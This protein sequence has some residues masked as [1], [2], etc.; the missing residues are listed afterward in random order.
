MKIGLKFKITTRQRQ[1]FDLIKRYK[2]GLFLGTACMLL[3]AASSAVSAL[4]I[5]PVMDDIFVKQDIEMLRLMPIVVVVVF[6][7]RGL[8]D[9]GQEYY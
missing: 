7:L 2:M 3:V 4:L 9:Y 6:F 1:L 8:G 5:K